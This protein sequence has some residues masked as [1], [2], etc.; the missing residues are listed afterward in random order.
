EQREEGFLE[1]LQQEYPRIN[2]LVENQHIGTT[3]EESKTNATNILQ[4]HRDDVDGVFAVCE[5]H[6][7]GTLGALEELEL[8]GKVKFISFDPSPE[9]V[10]A[11]GTNPPKVHGIVLQ[12][13]VR[14]GYEAVVSM[15]R[16]LNGEAVEER[17]DTGVHVATPQNMHEPEMQKLLHPPRFD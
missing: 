10:I 1:T 17:I 8:A 9:L 12:D 11:M 3:P 2:V 6:A 16:H 4:N 14:M 5:P 7:T 15:V 13:P